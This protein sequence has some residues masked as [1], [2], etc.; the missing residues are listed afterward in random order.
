MQLA[1]T[2]RNQ[3]GGGGI[4]GIGNR[5]LEDYRHTGQVLQSDSL[6]GPVIIFPVATRLE[7]LSLYKYEL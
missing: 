6:S 3:Q 7:I 4:R 2:L 1:R 5:I